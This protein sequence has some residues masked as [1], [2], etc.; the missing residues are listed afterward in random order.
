MK[1]NAP[2]LFLM[3]LIGILLFIA[4]VRHGGKVERENKAIAFYLSMAPTKATAYSPT[5][6]Q[7]AEIDLVKTKPNACG[8]AFLYPS[9]MSP[10]KT[11]SG[12]AQIDSAKHTIRF[13]C[14]LDNP[15]FDSARDA[16][17]PQEDITVANRKIKARIQTIAKGKAYS[18]TLANP[19]TGK[20][21]AFLIDEGM[22][23]LFGKTLE[24]TR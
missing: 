3:A 9:T 10:V 12:E 17:L 19:L 1:R 5:P 2:Y 15:L 16:T 6:E 11:A 8:I 7:E 21:M 13:S 20:P 24:F 14:N 23:M 18:F 22:V 4:G